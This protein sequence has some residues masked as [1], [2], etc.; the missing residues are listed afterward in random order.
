MCNI[1]KYI[2]VKPVSSIKHLMETKEITSSTKRIEI[3]D[4]L[5]GFSL[6]GIVIVHMVENYI[7]GPPP[8]AF[9]EVANQGIADSI[10]DGFILFLLRGKFFALFSFLFGL[11]FFIQMDNAARKNQY[12][13]GRFLW[14]LILL[15]VIG[16][17]HSLFYAGDI[18]TIYAMLGILL[19]PFYK[20][21]TKWIVALAALLFLGLG[22]YVFF[23]VNG[24]DPIFGLMDYTPD[25][26]SLM[27][28][29]N[30]LKNGSLLD[31]FSTNGYASHLNKFDF[32]FGVFG[33]GYLTFG[34]F[35]LG[36][37]I[38][39]IGFFKTYE[40][41]KKFVKRTLI[42]SIVLYFV[43]IGL[44]AVTFGSLGEN[45]TFDNWVAMVG[46]S[47]YDLNNVAMT[48]IL[49]CLFVMLYKRI[50]PKKWL[51]TFIPYGRMALTNYFLQSVIGTFI[52][53]GWGLGYLGKLRNI[54][55]FA[56]AIVIIVFQVL[57]SKWWLKRYQYGPLE[58]IWRS[59]TFFKRFPMRK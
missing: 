27:E 29:Y 17:L 34:F 48:F 36:M 47:A 9:A 11:S 30:T 55:T 26:P 21:G 50:K 28:Y 2:D 54:Y 51:S 40:D 43:S 32:Q 25:S 24:G 18:L 33:R 1:F 8:S 37:I 13:G 6:A 20:I 15:L 53:F 14:R 46:L 41:N 22:R 56:I 23:T 52:L 58:W 16:Y 19:I 4:A 5:R 39:R 35:L 57:F 31:V 10:V 45:V 44:M 42:W 3:V 12:F 7:A 59:A 38:G 49:I